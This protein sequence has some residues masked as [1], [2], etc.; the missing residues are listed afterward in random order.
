MTDADRI[1]LAEAMGCMPD[2]PKGFERWDHFAEMS[3]ENELM[4]DYLKSV[5]PDPKHDA[6][7]CE[8]L[9]RWLNG[10]GWIVRISIG[11]DAAD[12]WIET[13]ANECH[14]WSGYDWK[15][16]VCELTLKVIP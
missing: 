5:L 6:N 13:L 15:Q 16:G 14:D 9:I 3:K 7:D 8:A 1:R 11:P 4:Q 2:P 12:V 10:K